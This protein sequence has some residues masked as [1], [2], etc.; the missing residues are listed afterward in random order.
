[1]DKPDGST[2]RLDE[3]ADVSSGES[4]SIIN[5]E[6]VSRRL[7]VVVTVS[8]DRDDVARDI[9]ASVA[10]LTFPR[11]YH[12]E[13]ISQDDNAADTRLVLALSIL[14]LLT[15][16]LL[17]QVVIGAW[18]ITAVALGAIA[19]SM[20]GGV[21]AAL[22]AGGEATVGTMLGFLAVLTIAVRNVLALVGAWDLPRGS[23][24]PFGRDLVT[25]AVSE[26]SVGILLA[27]SSAALVLL[28]VAVLGRQP[29][30]EIV[31]P[32]AVV[33]LGGVVTAVLVP[34]LLLPSLYLRWGEQRE[35]DL[36]D[37]EAVIGSSP[38]ALAR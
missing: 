29:G 35:P 4:F 12:A 1:M 30:L 17:L 15:G 14:A 6:S 8:G 5:R 13:V 37:D 25:Q 16:V 34:L 19:V 23:G 22:L 28:P 11:E 9:E 20:L 24:V 38:G 32:M 27:G 10:G 2:V 3:V 18:R 26:R 31:Q 33:V 21:L 7:D 36:L